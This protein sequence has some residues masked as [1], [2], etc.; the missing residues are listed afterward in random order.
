[1]FGTMMADQEDSHIGLK[2]AAIPIAFDSL[3]FYPG[4][5]NTAGDE[6]RTCCRVQRDGLHDLHS[7]IYVSSDMTF[8]KPSIIVKGIRCRELPPAAAVG[9]GSSSPPG[10]PATTVKGPVGTL[11]WKPDLTLLDEAKLRGYIEGGGGSQSELVSIVDLAAHK[12]PDAAILEIGPSDF[13]IDSLLPVL[14]SSQEERGKNMRCSRYTVLVPEAENVSWLRERISVLSDALSCDVL[15]P[16]ALTEAEDQYDI[17]VVHGGVLADELIPQL[18]KCVRA[19][20]TLLTL[21]RRLEDDPESS[22]VVIYES[23]KSGWS[24]EKGS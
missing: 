5:P 14:S 23:R 15:R 7:D 21:G 3:I 24:G 13:V 12:N 6:L 10:S 16:D 8:D 2:S 11:V 22:W 19:G 18:K 9:T 4:I 17:V 1:M 20:G